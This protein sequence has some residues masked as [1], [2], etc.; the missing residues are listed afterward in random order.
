MAAITVGLGGGG[1]WGGGLWC[2]DGRIRSNNA[3]MGK[4]QI[5]LRLEIIDIQKKPGKKIYNL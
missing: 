1:T 2:A 5:F 4:I 3:A